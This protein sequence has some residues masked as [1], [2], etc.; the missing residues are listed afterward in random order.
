M[1]EITR[2]T[3]LISWPCDRISTREAE[4]IDSPLFTIPFQGRKSVY[5]L[6]H[7]HTAFLQDLENPLS[8]QR[9]QIKYPSYI[10]KNSKFEYQTRMFICGE[11]MS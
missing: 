4:I 6:P 5:A 8:S 2:A 10:R 11:N 9:M 1:R 7:P 3:V